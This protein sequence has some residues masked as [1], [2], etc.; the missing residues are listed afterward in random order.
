MFT[1]LKSFIWKTPEVAPEPVEMVEQPEVP[2]E[3]PKEE[4]KIE[5]KATKIFNDELDNVK[6]ELNM[7]KKENDKII[8]NLKEELQQ[9][10]ANM[11]DSLKRVNS[12]INNKKVKLL[13]EDKQLLQ[14][15][16]DFKS[17]SEEE[18]KIYK[19]NI[20]NELNNIKQFFRYDETDNKYYYTDDVKS[21]FNKISIYL[22]DYATI[23]LKNPLEI[24]E[25]EPEVE[26]KFTSLYNIDRA[27]ITNTYNELSK[28]FE[29]K[30]E[31]I[32]TIKERLP[33]FE[34]ILSNE[35]DI[36]IKTNV[37]E[38][39][40]AKLSGIVA[41]IKEGKLRNEIIMP[42][43]V[44]LGGLLSVDF[45]KTILVK[46]GFKPDE[47]DRLAQTIEELIKKIDKKQPEQPQ[48][49]PQVPQPPQQSQPI[50]IIIDDKLKKLKAYSVGL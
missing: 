10:Q 3:E 19:T 37:S 29:G 25:E 30:I 39:T 33:D 27:Y 43:I 14:I 45:I 20:Q 9:I 31:G 48:Q 35:L 44:L 38:M 22:N 7:R 13:E 46:F 12:K 41:Y 24:T 32:K 49:P 17:L 1:Y 34:R 40:K 5:A 8:A 4:L 11:K 21:V 15:V 47:S 36:K 18:K 28:T 2:K 16:K 23:Q 50:N 42:L 26:A 6:V